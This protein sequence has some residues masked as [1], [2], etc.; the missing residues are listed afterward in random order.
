VDL[1][2]AAARAAE[3]VPVVAAAEAATRKKWA[4]RKYRPFSIRRAC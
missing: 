1:D 2:P 4:V 3:A